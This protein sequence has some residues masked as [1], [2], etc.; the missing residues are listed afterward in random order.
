[1]K[2]K[3]EQILEQFY[4]LSHNFEIEKLE[5]LEK[6]LEDYDGIDSLTCPI[7]PHDILLVVKGIKHY[8]Q[9][10]NIEE[11]NSIIESTLTRLP[12]EVSY[13]EIDHLRVV[14]WVAAYAINFGQAHCLTLKALKR[15][16]DFKGHSAYKNIKY[17]LYMNLAGRML[18]AKYLEPHYATHKDAIEDIFDDFINN[19]LDM[20]IAND[21]KLFFAV[22]LTRKGI[23]ERNQVLIHAGFELLKDVKDEARVVFHDTLKQDIEKYL[24]L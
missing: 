20:C 12:D 24:N 11:M 22:N 4:S 14:M 10:D 16:E 2:S 6:E 15:L 13:W 8:A 9:T 19:A 17:S 5:S 18:R 1:M 3:E 21:G 23:F 7:F